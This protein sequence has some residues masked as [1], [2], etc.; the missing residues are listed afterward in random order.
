MLAGRNGRK[1]QLGDRILL[2]LGRTGLDQS[3]A[4]TLCRVRGLEGKKLGGI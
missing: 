3:F 4:V 1:I 2:G